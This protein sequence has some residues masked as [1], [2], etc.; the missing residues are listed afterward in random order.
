M[1]GNAIDTLRAERDSDSTGVEPRQRLVQSLQATQL[2]CLAWVL[3]LPVSQGQVLYPAL[4]GIFLSSVGLLMIRGIRLSRSM[5]VAWGVYYAWATLWVAV[6]HGWGNPGVWHQAALWLGLPVLWG[7]WALSMHRGHVRRT[8]SVMLGVGVIS[9]ALT[10]WLA[11]SG[12]WNV[13]GPPAWLITL[14]DMRINVSPVNGET[15][16]SYFGLSSLVGLGALAITAALQPGTDPWL[17]RRRWLGCAAVLIFASA[18]ASGRNGLLLALVVVAVTASAVGLGVQLRRRAGA[19]S[20]LKYVAS[21]A[22]ATAATV[23]FALTP[24]GVNLTL[25]ASEVAS[26]VGLSLDAGPSDPPPPVVTADPGSDPINELEVVSD[27]ARADSFTEL[28]SAIRTSPLWGHGFGATLDSGYFRSEERPWMFEAEPLQVLMNVGLLGCVVV[29][30]PL[31]LLARAAWHT[32][33]NG[34]HVNAVVA[35][36]AVGCAVALASATNPYLQAPGHGWMLFLAGA[37]IYA[38]HGQ[39]APSSTLPTGRQRRRH[40]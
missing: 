27:K 38:A 10:L 11:A 6:S 37:L 29:L 1:Q 13:T 16:F 23:A 21:V 14:Q 36:L 32:L 8:I 25:L 22:A 9:A 35:G 24:L 30:F 15:E 40:R 26:V 39:A 28:S 3:W 18:V 33:R 17:P 7:S 34:R 31:L 5:L 12:V 2:I 19:R 20:F 4:L